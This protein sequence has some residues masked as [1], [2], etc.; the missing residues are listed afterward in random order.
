MQ[1]VNGLHKIWSSVCVWNA[2]NLLANRS[3]NFQLYMYMCVCVWVYPARLWAELNNASFLRLNFVW[4]IWFLFWF[5]VF[6]FSLSLLFFGFQLDKLFAA[7]FTP[8][9]REEKPVWVENAAYQSHSS[10]LYFS[11]SYSLSISFSFLCTL[12]A[13]E[14][15]TGADTEWSIS[16]ALVT[17]DKP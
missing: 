17:L 13:L 16:G 10:S 9:A 5:V 3:N 14:K 8:W 12:L 2:I 1:N 7:L 11:L 6:F 4:I 15:R